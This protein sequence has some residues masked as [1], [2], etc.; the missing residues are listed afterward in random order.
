M[1]ESG[2]SGSDVLKLGGASSEK[3]GISEGFHGLDFT[4]GEAPLDGA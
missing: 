2:L 1:A 3:P 4:V